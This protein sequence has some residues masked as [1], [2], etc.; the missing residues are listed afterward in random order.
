MHPLMRQPEEASGIAAGE[1]PY[2]TPEEGIIT[3]WAVLHG[4]VTLYLAGHLDRNIASA[5]ELR[6]VDPDV[7]MEQVSFVQEP[8]VFERFKTAGWTTALGGERV[9]LQV[10]AMRSMASGAAFHCAYR[11]ATQQ[12]FLEAHE[13]APGAELARAA[14]KKDLG[15]GGP[16]RGRPPPRRRRR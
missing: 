2:R 11:H 13:R 9:K 16:K 1:L 5:D 15:K 12:A 7:F 3:F 10:F 4:F 14:W 6:K 8:L